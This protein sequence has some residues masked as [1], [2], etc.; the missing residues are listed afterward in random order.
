MSMVFIGILP[1]IPFICDLVSLTDL[2]NGKLNHQL[3]SQVD[4]PGVLSLCGSSSCP[5]DW[6]C[7]GRRDSGRASRPCGC[8]GGWTGAAACSGHRMACCRRSTA[9]ARRW[10]S[11]PP[12]TREHPSLSTSPSGKQPQ[13]LTTHHQHTLHFL[14]HHYKIKCAAHV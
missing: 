1:P 11:P 8:S 4:S 5:C 13:A 14:T 7:G 12:A 3:H 2:G 6:P 10:E 9:W